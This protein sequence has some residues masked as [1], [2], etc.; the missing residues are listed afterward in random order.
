MQTAVDQSYAAH[1]SRF[2]IAIFEA[3]GAGKLGGQG[4]EQE[5][6]VVLGGQLD[7]LLA[8]V[9]GDLDVGRHVVCR[10]DRADDPLST[11]LAT[12]LFPL[13]VFSLLPTRA[14]LLARSLSVLLFLSLSL[15]L[16]LTLFPPFLPMFR[17]SIRFFLEFR[18]SVLAHEKEN[19]KNLKLA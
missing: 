13:V 3:A 2:R 1:R 12:A 11:D 14:P 15:S 10:V 4:G 18:P 16:L 6:G 5:R 7:G 19:T 17:L 9:L 8:L